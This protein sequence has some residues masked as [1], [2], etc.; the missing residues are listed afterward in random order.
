MHDT[1]KKSELVTLFSLQQ[2]TQNRNAFSFSGANTMGAALLVSAGSKTSIAKIFSIW[3]FSDSRA[4]GAVWYGAKGIGRSS[5]EDNAIRCLAGVVRPKRAVIY[6]LK[7]GD[8][9]QD[10]CG[11]RVQI[12]QYL[13]FGL[14]MAFSQVLRFTWLY[15]FSFLLH[16]LHLWLDCNGGNVFVS[17]LRRCGFP[18]ALTDLK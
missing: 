13:Y 14:P 17:A 3:R 11:I 7:F 16:T 1:M 8:Q 10:I 9:I 6:L 12:V 18:F 15:L 2:S 4:Q 5:S